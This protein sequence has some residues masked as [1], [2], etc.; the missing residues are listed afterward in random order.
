MTERAPAD[1]ADLVDPPG[2]P[3]GAAPRGAGVEVSGLSWRPYGRARPV[4]H[5]L[6]LRIAAGERVLLA[7]PSGS[8]KSTLLR[9]LAGLL[10]TAD[11][12]ELAGEV[13]L[14]GEPERRAGSVGLVLQDPG[15]GVVASSIGRDV[16]FG[17][18]NVGVARDAMPARVAAALAEVGLDLP[19]DSSP[20]TLSGGEAQR[21]AL[22][23]ALVMEP[24]LLLLDEPTAML[25]ADTAAGVRAVVADVVERRGLTLVVV[26]HRLTGWLDLVDRLVVLDGDGRVVA[27]DA[28]HDVLAEHADSL[29]RQGIWVPGAP[30]PQP[31]AVALTPMPLASAGVV[32]PGE[33]VVTGT[34][35]GVERR[36]RRLGSTSRSTTA[37]A[38]AD[39]SVAAGR[40][41]ALTGPSGAGKSTL[42]AAVGGLLAPT[43]GHVDVAAPLLPGSGGSSERPRPPHGW[44]SVDLARVV[45]WVPQRAATAVVG[46]TVRDDVLTTA[47]ALGHDGS[48]AETRADELL[49]TLGL[50]RLADTD[51]RH[52]SG[53][54]QR[55]LAVASAIAHGPALVL[56]DEPTVGQD[57]LTWA[58]VMGTLE[59]ARREGAGVLVT[60]HDP[61]VVDRADHEVA[62]VRPPQPAADPEPERRP[63]LARVGPLAL[64]V[65]ALCV[66]PLPAL[67][68]SWRQ[69][70]LVLAV[71]LTLGLVG[72]LAPGPGR[73]PEG[74]LRG[75][76]ARLAPAVVAVAGVAW[77]A[78]LL[79]GRD[80]EI[81]AGAALR[82]L[83]LIVPS[84]FVVGFIDPERLGDHLAQRVHL[85]ARPVVAATAALQRLQSFD[86]LWTELM[87][88]RR[89]RG[90]RADHGLVRR[91]AEAVAVTG[92]LLVGALGQA[93][94]LAL[95]MDA[96]GF[97]GAHRRSW[98]G[99]APWRLADSLAV[100]GGLAIIGAALAARALVA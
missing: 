88:T 97:A 8:G 17:L 11:S 68:G 26:E 55:R 91:G 16:A 12:G 72:L 78:W 79:G 52:L 83:C 34:G 24:R 74:R 65:A 99:P 77:S 15:A 29:V 92:G 41:T 73:R 49:A 3:S 31:L 61:G 22:A 53:G 93:A 32:A 64:L 5:G 87:T 6:D 70:L 59:A 33:R 40:L 95:A 10:L 89:V 23:G 62:L 37:V 71:E 51:P 100:G 69:G 90:I 43:S 80:L 7:G 85:P 76:L 2:R 38:G 66:L 47:R 9:A 86:D 58:A 19:P 75:V 25:D 46:R 96:R 44:P 36:S 35:L 18:E 63:L 21:L 82:V 50:A 28:P 42:M 14:D 57:R 94:G 81:A 30:E 67:L 13:T 48:D 54:E 20:A 45:A 27:D 98:A 39:L 60:T 56:A 1:A 84:A 4:L